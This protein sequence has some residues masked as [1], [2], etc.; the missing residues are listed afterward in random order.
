MIAMKDPTHSTD[1]A[2]TGALSGNLAS[3]VVTIPVGQKFIEECEVQEDQLDNATTIGRSHSLNSC[4][5]L[6]WGA[7]KVSSNLAPE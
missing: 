6:R 2:G 5:T 1:A 7:L 4:G 3:K